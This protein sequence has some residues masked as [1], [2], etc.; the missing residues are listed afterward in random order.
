MHQDCKRVLRSTTTCLGERKG[1]TREQD[2]PIVI[3]LLHLCDI[4]Y[5]SGD[6]SAL[7]LKAC[8]CQ[9]GNTFFN[10][11]KSM[12]YLSI[13]QNQTEGAGKNSVY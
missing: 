1:G 13:Q 7:R 6:F 2:E 9:K 3:K 8:W 4:I 11:T 12:L 10:Q 5:F